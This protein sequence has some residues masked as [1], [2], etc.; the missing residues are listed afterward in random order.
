M[1]AQ[2]RPLWVV[3]E[4]QIGHQKALVGQGPILAWLFL[5][6]DQLIPGQQYS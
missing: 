4:P 5:L 2:P 6:V 1:F 3:L